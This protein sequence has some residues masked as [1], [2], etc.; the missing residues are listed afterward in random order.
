MFVG[1]FMS[2][3]SCYVGMYHERKEMCY[4]EILFR[5]RKIEALTLVTN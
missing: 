5:Y 2:V 4:P 1:K 3:D